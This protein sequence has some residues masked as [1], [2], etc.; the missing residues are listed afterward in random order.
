MGGQGGGAAGEG[1]LHVF[2]FTRQANAWSSLSAHGGF[3]SRPVMAKLTKVTAPPAGLALAKCAG[4]ILKDISLS[5]QFR[6]V[7]AGPGRDRTVGAASLTV[8]PGPGAD[9]A[10][11][12]LPTW[13]L[14]LAACYLLSKAIHSAGGS[15]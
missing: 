13:G 2:T 6:L 11:Q 5:T 8:N 14:R 12:E 7:G 4:A 9:K 15:R 1:A 3:S 10:Q